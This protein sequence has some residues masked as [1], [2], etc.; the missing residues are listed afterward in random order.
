[1][2]RKKLSDPAHEET[3]KLI[4]KIERK[5]TREYTQAANEV[6]KKLDKYFERFAVKDA[7]KLSEVKA[8]VLS[9]E[10]YLEWRKNQML[11]GDRWKEMRNLLSQD[12]HNANRIARNIVNGYMPEAYAMNFN[13][14]VF[15]VEKLAYVNTSFTLYDRSTVERILRD[16][17]EI[18]QPP[19]KQ[20]LKTFGDFDAYKSGKPV[21][22]RPQTQKAFDKLI[23]EN[24][25]VRWQEG[26]LQS[27]TLQSV[28]QGESIPNM[29]KRIAN[30]M[31]ELNRRSTIRYARTAMTEAENAGRVDS[32]K[33]ARDMGIGVSHQWM[34]THDSR[35]RS[36]HRRLDGE[37]V[38][39]GEE[40]S[41]GCR[42]PGD[43]NGAPEEIWNCR[44]TLVPVLTD[45]DFPTSLAYDGR[46]D[47][48][49]YDE[50]K[51]A[52]S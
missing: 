11:I 26:K 24:R 38:E 5:V 16:D 34:A 6:Q 28:L 31:G 27:V 29:A 12:L 42:Y 13:Y 7:K 30:T 46:I 2:A 17:P 35:T 50:W 41:N 32:Y 1:M 36:S 19:G 33:R 4:K 44:C 9:R 10:K 15:Q 52:H 43:P 49:T 21:K 48:M 20:M 18:L 3:D 45:Y 23:R 25:D 40:F 47:G 51:E 22:I 37:I 39:V 14:G 8:G